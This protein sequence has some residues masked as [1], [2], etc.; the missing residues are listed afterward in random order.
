MEFDM[1]TESGRRAYAR[2]YLRSPLGVP[3][4]VTDTNFFNGTDDGFGNDQAT[5]TRYRRQA[6][7]VGID[8]TGKVYCPELCRKGLSGG[9]DSAAWVPRTNGR[10]HIK[11]VLQKRRWSSTGRVEVAE[12]SYDIPDEK[13][14]YEP[15]PDIVEKATMMDIHRNKLKRVSKQERAAMKA[16]NAKLL[17]G[18]MNDP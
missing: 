5:R 2:K 1:T 13:E 8:T 6:R 16:E 3:G 17:A 4:I 18:N 10:S 15:A 14:H 12:P 7:A 11:S 9:R